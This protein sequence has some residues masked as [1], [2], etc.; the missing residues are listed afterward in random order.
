MSH[1]FFVI[2]AQRPECGRS[3]FVDLCFRFRDSLTTFPESASV[4]LLHAFNH[5]Y[6]KS[7]K[8]IVDIRLRPL[9][10]AAPGGSCLSIRR[11]VKSRCPLLSHFEYTLLSCRQFLTV[12]CKYEVIH[13]PKVH[14]YRNAVHGTKSHRQHAQELVKIGRAVSE[15]TYKHTDTRTDTVITILRHHDRERSNKMVSGTVFGASVPEECAYF[16]EYLKAEALIMC[17]S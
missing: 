8:A 10:S 12:T 15:Q 16:V 2:R 5:I 1:E 13:K 14:K 6:C 17:E 4:P 9:S 3:G 7:N 11:G